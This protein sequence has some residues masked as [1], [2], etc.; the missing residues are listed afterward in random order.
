[1]FLQYFRQPFYSKLHEA[2]V[3]A[4]VR[5]CGSLLRESL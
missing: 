1:V 4:L 2:V 3:A 5:E